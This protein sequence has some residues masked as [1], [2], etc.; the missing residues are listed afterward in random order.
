MWHSVFGFSTAA[1]MK[2]HTKPVIHTCWNIYYLRLRYLESR[3]FRVSPEYVESV[4][5]L[6]DGVCDCQALNNNGSPKYH[7]W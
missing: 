6:H 4:A 3:G 5:F 2:R 1:V 7:T